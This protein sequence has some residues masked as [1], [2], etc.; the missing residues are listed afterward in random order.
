[1][2][3]EKLIFDALL[4]EKNKYKSDEIKLSSIEARLIG[5]ST[6]F[7]FS[8]LISRDFLLDESCDEVTMEIISKDRTDYFVCISNSLGVIHHRVN[9]V[10]QELELISYLEKSRPLMIEAL[11][12]IS[13]IKLSDA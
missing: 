6:A 4:S 3:T 5:E 1:M 8:I 2:N 13:T 9:F 12:K 10:N 7:I 11:Q